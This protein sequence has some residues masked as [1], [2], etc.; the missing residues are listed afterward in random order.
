MIITVIATIP[1]DQVEYYVRYVYGFTGEIV[2]QAVLA[3]DTKRTR[4]E[5]MDI[6]NVKS[7]K[8]S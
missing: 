2:I 8:T 4:Q 7:L 3:N 1:D 5:I 6:L